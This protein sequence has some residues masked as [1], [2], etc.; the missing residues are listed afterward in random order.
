[1]LSGAK[2]NQVEK[3]YVR[4][5]TKY[6]LSIITLII[7]GAVWEITLSGLSFYFASALTLLGVALFA[8]W[9]ILSNVTAS[10]IL[11]FIFPHNIGNRVRIV[12]GDNS[13]EG[14][15]LDIGSFYV[16]LD[17]ENGETAIYPNNLLMQKPV[18]VSKN[19]S[20]TH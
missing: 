8:N 1:M 3:R 12:D 13:V 17:I 2:C 5:F 10:I 15:I 6:L 18:I 19:Q 14:E 11:F 16:L 7:L 4:K 20:T 9:S